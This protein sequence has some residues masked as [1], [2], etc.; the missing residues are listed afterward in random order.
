MDPQW[1]AAQKAEK[2]CWQDLWRGLEDNKCL[3]LVESEIT[4]QT[5][6]LKEMETALDISLN[7]FPAGSRVLDVGCGPVSYLSRMKFEGVKEGVDPLPYPDWVYEQYKKSG[8]HVNIVPFEEFNTENK[9][10]IILFYNALQHFRDLEM[11]AFKCFQILADKGVIYLSEY[12][13]I[14]CDDAHIQFLT[15]NLLND[16]FSRCGF[17]VV[18]YVI[19]ARLPGLVEM[20]GGRPVDLYVAKLTKAKIPQPSNS[21]RTTTTIKMKI[22]LIGP[23]LMPIPAKNWG[24]VEILMWNYKIYL[25]EIGHIVDIYNTKDLNSVAEAINKN[26]NDFI[27]LHYDEYIGFFNKALDKPYCCTSHYGY[28]LKPE[29][30]GSYYESIFEDTLRAPGIIALSDKIA[31]KYRGSGYNGF[32]RVLRNGAEVSKFNFSRQGNGKAICLGKVEPRKRQT[33]LSN[34]LRGRVHIDFVGPIIDTAFQENETCRYLGIWDK[35]YLYEHLTDYSCLVLLSDGEAAPL[36]VPEAFSAGLSIVISECASANLDPKEFITILPDEITDPEQVQTSISAQI[37]TN[38]NLREEIRE[39]AY[40]RF[41]WHLIA[42]EYINYIE[43]FRS[44]LMP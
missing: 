31:Q 21:Q 1:E 16:I 32:L 35:P 13:H 17:Q 23:G 11:V 33:L 39:Y 27:H 24:A 7:S 37:S 19:S 44:T 38:A 5:F 34:I 26:S 6:I 10:D 14:P 25:E 28:I 42:K 8:F 43:N 29:M 9:Y 2:D 40:G 22:A 18:S 20:G 3:T 41:D 4:K 36:V 12:L 15:K 30:W